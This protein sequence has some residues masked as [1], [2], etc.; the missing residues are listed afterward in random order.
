M[1]RV[2][3][4]LIAVTVPSALFAQPVWAP[5]IDDVRSNSRVHAGPF[6]VTPTLLLKEIGIDNNVFNAAGDQKSDFTFTM[7]PKADVWMPV[8]RRALL[9]ATLAT[10]LVW[11]AEYDAER[12]V[13]P[14][15]ALR[16]EVYLNRVRLFGEHDYLN[17]RQRPNHEIDVRSR[18]V[19]ETIRAGADIRL[20]P[21]LSLEV[22][23]RRFE[24]RYEADA[25]FDG[26]SLQRTLNRQTEG[27]QLTARH[28]VTPLTTL[29]LRAETLRDSF[30]FSPARNSESYRVMPGVEFKP[31]ALVKGS[32]YIGYRRFTPRVR[33]VLP[34]FSGLVGQLGL[35][36]TLLGST[37]FGVSYRR[38]LT[39]S[40]EELQPFFVDNSTGASIRRALGPRFDVLLSAD[41][42]QYAYRDALPPR[43][44]AGAPPRVDVTWNYAGSLG[45][46]LGRDGRLAFGAS[47]WQRDSSTRQFRNYDNLRIGASMSYGF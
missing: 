10:D 42:H 5:K 20:T 38:D 6:Y 12:S 11:Y 9:G 8:A 40:Y 18:H 3:T 32:A 23:G 1:T 43:E 17:T 24:T 33:D 35:S 16:A 34:E 46:R 39:Y 31:Q 2:V 37:T 41:R 36:Y 21:K 27:L 4:F 28:H 22:A 44:P 25:Q 45:Y 19:Q 15:L 14:Q 26:T 30:V 13:D 7:A 29:A 47:Y